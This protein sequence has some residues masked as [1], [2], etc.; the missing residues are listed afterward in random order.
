MTAKLFFIFVYAL[1]SRAVAA[2]YLDPSGFDHF[3]T[4]SGLSHNTATAIRRDPAGYIWI[5]TS[6][7]LNRF[8]GSR[9][10]NFHSTASSSSLPAEDIRDITW[11]DNRRLAVLTS[12][13]HIIDTKNGSTHNV[14]VPYEN[15][16]YQFKFNMTV[17]A[18]GDEHKNLYLLTRSGFYH[19]GPDDQLLFRF[20]YYSGN[21]VAVNHFF[22]G[23]ELLELD[24]R[25][26]LVFGAGGP[27]VY[28]KPAKKF[29]KMR[30]EDCPALAGEIGLGVFKRFFQPGR[31]QFLVYRPGS[32][33]LVYIDVKKGTSTTSIMPFKPDAT[34]VH[35]RSKLFP[36]ND[37]T[38]FLTG[39]NAGFY[40][41][42]FSSSTGSIVFDSHCYFAGYRC[43]GLLWDEKKELWIAT[44]KGVFHENPG[45]A[46]VKLAFLPA[47][48]AASVPGLQLDDIA[49]VADKIVAGS[50]GG[51]LY[52]FNRRTMEF[53]DQ[54]RYG[55]QLRPNDLRAVVKAGPSLIFAAGLNAP[56]MFDPVTGAWHVLNPPLW[57]KKDHWSADAYRA[58]DGSIWFNGAYIYGYDP[59]TGS[60]ITLPGYDR[61][62]DAPNVICEDN[63]GNIWLAG[64]GIARYN[65]GLGRYD[66]YLDTLPF[67][68]MPDKQVNAMAIDKEDRIW[69]SNTNNGLSFYDTKNKNFRH[70][71][72]ADGLPDNN[73][74]SLKIVDSRLWIAS[75]SGVACLDLATFDIL[76][77]GKEDGFPDE[78]I[79]RGA[80]FYCDEQDRSIYIAFARSLARFDP[81]LLL[82]KKEP[83][84][85]FIE[86]LTVS[87]REAVFLPGQS[88][89]TTW[90]SND[91]N[92]TIGS[93]NFRDG[94]VQQF[95]YRIINEDQDSSWI[96]LQRQPNFSISNL[97]PG[98]HIIQVKVFRADNR[99]PPQVSNFTIAVL[100][101][102]WQQKWFLVL[103]GAMLIALVYFFVR[104]RIALVRRKEMVKTQ[105]E[106]LKADDYKSQMELEQISNYF[107]S[108]LADKK[109]ED[110]V[111]WDVAAN[112]IGRMK[113]EEC[114]IYGW[115][116]DKTRMVQKAAYGP[117]GRPDVI[118]ESGFEVL[119]GQGIVGHVI[120]TL[121]PELVPDTRLDPRYRVDDA[122][123][124]SEISVPIIHDNELLGVIDSENSK[125]NYFS[126]RD[127][128]ILTTIAMLI[129]NKLKQIESQR[130]LEIKQKEL[131]GINEQL[132]E[133]RLNALQSQMNPHFVFN[134]LNSIKLMILEGENKKASRYLSKF[135]LMIRM[136]LEHSK[137][138]FVTI[139]KN[140]SYLNAYLEMEQL[141][142]DESFSYTIRVEEDV[143]SMEVLIPSL[144]LQPLVENAIWHGLLPSEKEKKIS[145][146]FG[147]QGDQVVCTVEDNGIGIIAANRLRHVQRPLH[148]SVSLENLKRRIRIM[149]EKYDA[150]CSLE[151]QD[152]SEIDGRRTGTRA[153]LKLN[154]ITSYQKA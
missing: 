153:V 101:P 12:G 143:D 52:V 121:Q 137:E 29:Y 148:R 33:S 27:Y 53:E 93:I 6:N 76:S 90:K 77:F 116:E 74:A 145:I 127:I 7:G 3:S 132:A 66:L 97:K 38:W 113:Y 135:A 49:V 144:M 99:W 119:P 46:A 72:N 78:P 118:A 134:A 85:I 18:V 80:N 82:H 60:Y 75:F 91:I 32:D 114:I 152:L 31:G 50:R 129:G 24:D 35:Y 30:P 110:E 102:L 4:A 59:V 141:R 63:S 151:I 130:S 122:I 10:I 14:F 26:L 21:E 45:K 17:A 54:V 95:C 125:A 62:L 89:T 86:S 150:C 37:S 124:L 146:S 70:F 88:F 115:S 154:S 5:A 56:K 84:R 131:A 41:L 108:S 2:Q 111:L 9:F 57:N 96:Y 47:G 109:T 71:T 87:G 140:I 103:A 104:W 25:R 67:I 149:N 83:P 147:L 92:I 20:D 65:R 138:T 79:T 81:R 128:K 1:L 19:F 55:N 136:T 11:L 73:I 69:F 105:I 142:F 94:G 100:P 16:Y 61:L 51:G 68:K 36:F 43:S 126:E 40:R 58:S 28:E 106:K 39:H 23:S 112:L 139:D 64:H 34:L 13:T 22:F 44:N 48:T 15:Q 117:K 123:R 133:A 98:N 8:D 120:A 107:S 42:R